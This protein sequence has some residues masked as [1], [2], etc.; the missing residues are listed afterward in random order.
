MARRFVT[1]AEPGL[2]GTFLRL[3]QAPQDVQAA[4]DG[5]GLR[6]LLQIAPCF[7]MRMR[8]RPRAGEFYQLDFEMSFV[9][10]EDVFR[11]D[12]AGAG[13]RVPG[14]RGFNRETRAR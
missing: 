3:P 4:A 9:H 14:I 8:A 7:R 6:P 1:G 11:G 2:I 10:Q 12:R 5:V 13:W